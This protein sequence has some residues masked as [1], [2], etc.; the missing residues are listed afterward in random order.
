MSGAASPRHPAGLACQRAEDAQ[1]YREILH[2][3]IEVGARLA[4]AID[5][6]AAEQGAAP[7]QAGPSEKSPAIPLQR[8]HQGLA[9]SGI[10]LARRPAQAP[11]TSAPISLS[12]ANVASVG[13][14]NSS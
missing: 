4:R 13:S 11:A 3:F 8:T 9:R 5:R 1:Y 2:E 14:T 6:Q 12:R 10:A 7:Q